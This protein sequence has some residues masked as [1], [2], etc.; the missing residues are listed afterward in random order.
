M[1]SLQLLENL[2]QLLLPPASREHVLG[3][4]HEKCKSSREYL[5]DA[6]SVLGPVIIGRIRR[7]IDWQVFLMETLAVYLSFSAAAWWLDQK[8][9]LYDQ[10]GFVRLAI[11]TAVTLAG[12]LMCNAYSDRGKQASWIKPILESAGT[13]A[14]SFLG[15][16]VIFD[17]S[18]SLAV[19]LPIMLYGSCMSLVLV[20]TLRM[21]FPP[22]ASDRFKVALLHETQ[23]SR[24]PSFIP[25]RAISRRAV[26]RIGDV[27]PSPRLRPAML[28][29]VSLAA[30]VL[31][32]ATI[33]YK[34]LR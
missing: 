8:D 22:I 14:L 21:L 34:L 16:A 29:A 7:T 27:P 20:A 5:K 33:V 31:L 24:K 4:L 19:P 6:A 1:S 13:L 10:A 12:L 17:T 26:Q 25:G 28:I 2:F 11:P 23:N 9:Y 30:A 18:A 3:D 15:Q 32:A